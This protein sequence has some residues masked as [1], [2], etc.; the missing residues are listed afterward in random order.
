M[1]IQIKK[2]WSESPILYIALVGRPGINKS[3]PLKFALSPILNMGKKN[4]DTFSSEYDKYEHVSSLS[5]KERENGGFDEPVK[6]I[7]KFLSFFQMRF[8]FLISY[9]I[10]FSFIVINWV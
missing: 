10:F 4:H 8:V 5:K 2:G 1:K 9:N 3:H 7:L 6:P